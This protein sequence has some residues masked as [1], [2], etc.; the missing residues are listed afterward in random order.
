MENCSVEEET[1]PTWQDERILATTQPVSEPQP[2]AASMPEV[3]NTC[4]FSEE[5]L[6]LIFDMRRDVVDQLHRQNILC[7][8]LDAL[9]DS[10]SGE[11]VKRRCPT[12]CQPYVFSPARPQPPSGDDNPGSPSV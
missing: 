7:R 1:P 4:H 11:P 6:Q 12:C 5:H 8:R 9:F 2:V 10:L 3:P